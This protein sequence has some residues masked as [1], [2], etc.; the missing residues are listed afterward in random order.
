MAQCN[1]CKYYDSNTTKEI[2]SCKNYNLRLVRF[3][4][5]FRFAIDEL[6]GVDGIDLPQALEVGKIGNYIYCGYYKD[7]KGL[8]SE[9][10]KYR[11]SNL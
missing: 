6:I 4:W 1:S 3:K 8:R 2:K 11:N 5:R 10:K 9:E 7:D